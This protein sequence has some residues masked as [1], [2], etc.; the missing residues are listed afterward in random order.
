MLISYREDLINESECLLYTSRSFHLG[1]VI[2]ILCKNH[3]FVGVLGF[4]LRAL[5]W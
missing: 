3:S 4:E 1:Q 2:A 5:S